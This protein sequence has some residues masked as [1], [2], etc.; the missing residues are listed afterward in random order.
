MR[1]TH[2]WR[3]NFFN[4]NC[5]FQRLPPK[6]KNRPDM[7]GPVCSLDGNR[8]PHADLPPPRI[9]AARLRSPRSLNG[10]LPSQVARRWPGHSTLIGAIRVHERRGDARSATP[11]ACG[12]IAA[13]HLSRPILIREMSK[14]VGVMLI[15]CLQP[16]VVTA[17]A[18][19]KAGALDRHVEAVAGETAGDRADR[20]IGLLFPLAR[21]LPIGVVELGGGVDL[22]AGRGA[23]QVL[24]SLA[25]RRPRRNRSRRT[26]PARTSRS[27]W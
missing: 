17:I 24:A 10:A 14:P 1:A 6:T 19:E 8:R 22:V 7:V 9:R 26:S 2:R 25:L 23:A 4:D 16:V 21:Q 3:R 27:P 15:D 12:A 5:E 13:Q 11:A 20:G 18:A